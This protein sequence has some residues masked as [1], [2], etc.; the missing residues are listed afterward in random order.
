MRLNL[1]FKDA[2]ITQV[3]Q[4]EF[5]IVFD[6]SNMNKPR[7]SQ[8][9]RVYIEHLNLP[10]FI[11]EAWGERGQLKGYFELRCENLSNNDYDSEYGNT[12]SCII[13]TSPL[14]SYKSF[15]NE[16]P[17][18]ISNFK[19]NQAFLQDRLVFTLKVY[20]NRGN[21]FDTVKLITEDVDKD[22][23]EYSEYTKAI[24]DLHDYNTKKDDVIKIT[25]KLE[26][27]LKTA[28]AKRNT[29]RQEYYNARGFLT[30]KLEEY[31]QRQISTGAGGSTRQAK[32]LARYYKQIILTESVNDIKYLFEGNNLKNSD[33]PLSA[34]TEK[35]QKY[36]DVMK[37]YYKKWN[38]YLVAQGEYDQI[39]AYIQQLTSSNSEIFYQ[40]DPI[41]DPANTFNIETLLP[42][43]QKTLNY[44][45]DGTTQTGTVTLTY[46]NSVQTKKSFFVINDIVPNADGLSDGDTIKI[47]DSQ[48]DYLWLTKYNYYFTQENNSNPTGVSYPGSGTGTPTDKRV[49][50]RITRDGTTYSVSIDKN[51]VSEGFRPNDIIK[52]KG[53]QLGG[54]TGIND[55]FVKIKDVYVPAPSRTYSF[56][57]YIPDAF[58]NNGELEFEIERDNSG[59][60]DK[61]YTPTL[62][63][64]DTSN[65]KGYEV[66]DVF[67]ISGTKLDGDDGT[68]DATIT[69]K[70]IVQDVYKYTVDEKKAS[71][72]IPPIIID[73]SK[74]TKIA[75]LTGSAYTSGN[76]PD[77]FKLIVTSDNGVYLVNKASDD[78]STNFTQGDL[79]S[80]PGS[81]LTGKDVENDLV[82]EV[83]SVTAG[84]IDTV[85]LQTLLPG[86][87][88]F[89]ARQPLVLS[90]GSAGFLCEIEKQHGSTEYAAQV[91]NGVH[92]E[93]GDTISVDGTE[94]EGSTIT[95]NLTI[96]IDEVDDTADNIASKISP[97]GT[98]AYPVGEIGRILLADISGNGKFEPL[99]GT[100]KPNEYE[101]DASSQPAADEPQNKDTPGIEIVINGDQVENSV[102]VLDAS[103]IAKRADIIVKKNALVNTTTTQLTSLSSYQTQK[104]KSMNMSM[105]LYDEIPEYTQA[106]QDAIKGNTYSRIQNCQFKRI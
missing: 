5:K 26:L 35:N 63:N 78:A 96:T 39:L 67:K 54:V 76:I 66:G 14:S 104:L 74:T 101:I 4:S 71:H 69:V 1:N 45:V 55:C 11:D 6:L 83:T 53:E 48:L 10:E 47:D 95:N 102:S 88:P 90:A 57:K 52:I 43:G 29:L 58:P 21:P 79:I 77:N 22:S 59:P 81:A 9:A 24:K 36:S 75:D 64:D 86:Q 46:H 31:T 40:N 92:F 51:F 106:S 12:G 34:K 32:I 100:I 37:D 42:S 62:G 91:K 33:P 50:M 15:T 23:T 56:T 80:V 84:R 28:Q 87:T 20:D 82:I 98:V 103:I 41:F 44:T 85:G 49:S 30:Q 89:K 97:T 65:T 94:L 93:V 105:V 7:L 25:E 18:F 60:G 99:L 19:I 61:A 72:S 70:E 17:M 2:V 73:K 27:D 3:S 38:E 8:D 16:N 68:H 13:Y